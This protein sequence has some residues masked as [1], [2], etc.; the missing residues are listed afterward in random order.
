MVEDLWWEV[1][2]VHDF[3]AGAG[4][5]GEGLE[6]F[7][8]DVGVAEEVLLLETLMVLD[9]VLGEEFAQDVARLGVGDGAMTNEFVAT[10]GIR[11]GNIAGNGEDVFAL[12]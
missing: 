2:L 9:V 11:T 12:L 3:F 4:A 7:G 8:L 5:R 6:D 1:G 10:L